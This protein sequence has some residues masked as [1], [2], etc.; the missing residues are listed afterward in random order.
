MYGLSVEKTAA[1]LA[2]LANNGIKGSN[3]GTALRVD[4]AQYV[5]ADRASKIESWDELGLSM[6]DSEGKMRD[7]SDVMFDVG[8]QLQDFDDESRNRIFQRLFGA[9]GGGAA[10]A[11]AKTDETLNQFMVRMQGIGYCYGSSCR[12]ARHFPRP[13]ANP[14]RYSRD[15]A[16]RVLYALYGGYSPADN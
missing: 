5:P 9:Y 15:A 3:A 6:Y 1:A 8:T 16:D 4:A 2:V 12:H 14:G 11:L 10:A 7:L 13:H